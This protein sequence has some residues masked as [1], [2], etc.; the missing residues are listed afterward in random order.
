MT[1]RSTEGPLR[2]SI[3]HG[4]QNMP[5]DAGE[6]GQAISGRPPTTPETSRKTRTTGVMCV[7]LL[8]H[9]PREVRAKAQDGFTSAPTAAP[10]R[11][12]TGEICT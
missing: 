10:G 2:N 12:I 3:T 8:G 11:V 9:K 6:E 5:K 7:D 4:E 1:S